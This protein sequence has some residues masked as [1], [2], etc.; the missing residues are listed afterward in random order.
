MKKI[1]TQVALGLLC[2]A[3]VLAED[4]PIELLIRD[5]GYTSRFMTVDVVN[6]VKKSNA[7]AKAY[8]ATKKL[9]HP[10]S[11]K[12]VCISPQRGFEK[13]DILQPRISEAAESP[14]M[15]PALLRYH[16]A[17]PKADKITRKLAVTTYSLGQYKEALYWYT[18]TYQR[19]R[20]DLESLWNM[21]TIADSI[22]DKNQARVYLKEYAKADPNSAWGRMARN[23]LNSNYSADNMSESF[24]N[25]LAKVVVSD[26]SSRDSSEKQQV[27]NSDS[28]GDN[29]MIVVSGD[30]YDLESFVS[31]YRPNKNFSDNK[32]KD[33]DTLKG[34]SQTKVENKKESVKSSERKAAISE[35][36]TSTARPI[37]EAK[38]VTT[39]KV[40]DTT[41][42]QM[43]EVQAVKAAAL[44]DDSE[45]KA[46][47]TPLGAD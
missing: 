25:E 15:I 4:Y 18:L 34:N 42:S 31:S 8:Y 33:G 32:T 19:N 39:S 47:G 29:G 11:K 36:K 16:K 6:E 20:N 44:G 10:K 9:E 40:K 37:S 21:A 13:E 12:S 5:M 23:L 43:K 14:E 1:M 30:K 22:G 24:E 17:N 35:T 26:P 28:T 38:V 45:I 46:I 7:D 27:N 3:P 41:D 2:V